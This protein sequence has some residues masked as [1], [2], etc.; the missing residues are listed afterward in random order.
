M[1]GGKVLAASLFGLLLVSVTMVFFALEPASVAGAQPRGPIVI[2]GDEDF[3][4]ANGVV[5]GSGTT[6]DPFIIANWFIDA[7]SSDGITL[8]DT[9]AH[10]VL[11]DLSVRGGADTG[12]S[13]IRL[14]RVENVVVERTSL[15][16][17]WEP[18]YVDTAANLTIRQNDLSLSFVDSYF[19]SVLKLTFA[20]NTLY[21]SG[22]GIGESWNVS[23]ADNVAVGD[24][25]SPISRDGFGLSEVHGGDVSGNKV[26]WYTQAGF[27]IALSSDIEVSHNDVWDVKWGFVLNLDDGVVLNGNR[28]TNNG[29]GVLASD[30][31]R[32]ALRNNTFYGNTVS[33]YSQNFREAEF[34]GNLFRDNGRGIWQAD[35]VGSTIVGNTFVGD[36]L[37][38]VG[39]NASHFASHTVADNT[40]NGRPL[41]YFRDGQDLVL[42][43]ANAGQV[44]VANYSGVRISR[45]DIR[46]TDSPIEVAFSSD[47]QLT[48]NR[49]R[50]SWLSF[51]LT[52][53]TSAIIDQ[54]EVVNTTYGVSIASS[55]NVDVFGNH[56]SSVRDGI[57]VV[58]SAQVRAEY[59]T[60]IALIPGITGARVRGGLVAERSSEVVFDFNQVSDHLD[61]LAVADSDNVTA[62]NNTIRGSTRYGVRVLGSN[63]ITVVW[64]NFVEN[65]IQ[66]YQEGVAGMV[67]NL[68]YPAGGNFWSDYS[69][70]DQCSG[71]QQ[72][73]CG[74][75]DGILDAPYR[76]DVDGMDF[77]PLAR[78]AE[79]GGAPPLAAFIVEPTVG[80]LGTVFSFNASSSTDPDGPDTALLYRWDWEADGE[81]DTGW[82][83]EAV[84]THAFGQGGTFTVVLQVR[85]SQGLM[86]EER[87][88]IA[89]DA[90]G[91]VTTFEFSGRLGSAGWYVSSGFVYLNASDEMSSVEATYY[92][93][94]GGEFQKYTGSFSLSS[95][96]MHTLQFYSTDVFGNLEP[97]RT[98]SLKLDLTAPFTIATFD[99]IQMRN[100]WFR[101]PVLVSF[102]S[103]DSLSGVSLTWYRVDDGPWQA[104]SE[105]FILSG[106]G[107]HR[108]EFYSVDIAGNEE[109]LQT[110]TISI[111]GG[112]R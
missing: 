7:T 26:S 10:V 43:G 65:G 100:G 74:Q 89:V 44:I 94:D 109:A 12:H 78:P 28:L 82:V 86:D 34:T 72:D 87:R 59:N 57:D 92:S 75:P 101:G 16:L 4:E 91:P 30:S 18:M 103:F 46:D 99:G 63:S 1:R 6:S 106:R 67:W 49:L 62:R 73:S 79:T 66:A 64:N 27:Q 110:V 97:V 61:G 105:A 9:R 41:L 2:E 85:D 38:I 5:G 25:N 37:T 35:S 8:R 15:T 104:Y 31:N 48:E 32:V 84:A 112:S 22:V 39:T 24:P 111:R 55:A 21:R 102:D 107:T 54:N 80:G 51:L 60:V 83:S 50:S 71:P 90:Q 11:R 17:N 14:E 29:Y 58:D 88:R 52:G 68:S 13:G 3:T 33:V 53:V 19:R 76:F 56:I 45:M 40:V 23:I 96:G 47:V 98:A 20:E 42:E 108:I 36:G 81:F 69:V 95:E 70:P 77:Y 93:L